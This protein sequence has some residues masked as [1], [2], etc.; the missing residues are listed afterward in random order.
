MELSLLESDL[1]REFIE[2]AVRGGPVAPQ[3]PHLNQEF[4]VP[5]SM[6]FTSFADFTSGDYLAPNT[7]IVSVDRLVEM[8][9]KDGTVRALLRLFQLPIIKSMRE[10]EWNAPDDEGGGEEEAEFANQMFDLPKSMGG[11]SVSKAKFLRQTLLA[12]LE[13]FSVFEEVRTVPDHGPL[14]GKI[15]L[16]KPAHRASNTIEFLVDEHGS[17]TGVRQTANLKGSMNQVT[18]PR[19]KVWYYAVNEEENAMY[20]VSMFESA[21]HHWDIKRKL[22]YI[23]HIAAQMAATHGR[24]GKIPISASPDK[25][26]A[27][28]KMLANFGFNTSGTMPQDFDVVFANLNTSFDFMKLIDHQNQQIAKSVVAKFL[29]DSDRQVLIDNGGAD[30]SA[31]FFVMAIESVMEEIAESWSQY[32]MPKYIDWNFGSSKYPEFNFGVVADTTRDTIKELFTAVAVAQSSKWN[33][34]FILELEKK[35]VDRLGLEVDYNKV[36]QRKE[37]EAAEQQRLEQEYFAQQNQGGGQFGQQQG[38]PE[39]AA[40][41]A[42]GGGI[43]LS[44]VMDRVE[45]LMLARRESDLDAGR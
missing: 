2:L 8:R 40:A 24:I 28:Q 1:E 10:A 27:F 31:D 17:F 4:G 29:E 19:D 41:S 20:G 42:I 22:Y 18:I 34:E 37:E 3:N 43:T 44:G 15:V 9:Q 33:E 12:L 23:S 38:P 35:L 25:I 6:P 14:Q 26:A 39:E 45:K 36:D 5:V 32:L 13:G 30:A 7:A 21:W 11:M 16:K